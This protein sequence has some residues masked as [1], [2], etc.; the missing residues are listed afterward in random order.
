M[1]RGVLVGLL[2]LSSCGPTTSAQHAANPTGQASASPARSAAPGELLFA[3]S[4]G[5]ACQTSCP[6]TV[7]IVGVDG[8]TRAKTTFMPPMLPS[9]GCE[10]G[11]VTSPVQVAAGGVYYLDAA[12]AV[13][14]LRSS[15]DI[16]VVARFPI[17]T[18]QQVTW[19]AVSPDGTRFMASL[20]A[21]PPLVSPTISPSQGLS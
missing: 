19:F 1:K 9:V 4:Q 7:A 15:G 3:V 16:Q 21:F 14:R 20:V 12:G 5:G 6:S 10:G 18:S 8:R 11:F 17:L 13:R 2:L